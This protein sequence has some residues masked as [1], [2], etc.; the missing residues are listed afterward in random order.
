MTLVRR[1][2]VC[3]I[4]GAASLKHGS[5]LL[6]GFRACEN[7]LALVHVVLTLTIRPE[8]S[9]NELVDVV[10]VLLTFVNV[11]GLLVTS[12]PVFGYT[13]SVQTMVFPVHPGDVDKS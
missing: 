7:Q 3:R 11:V 6:A 5:P 9:R 10:L 4:T 12:P 1:P 2:S 13:R 8:G